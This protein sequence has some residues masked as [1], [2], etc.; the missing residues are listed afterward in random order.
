MKRTKQ[1]DL[2]RETIK[3]AKAAG[4]KS[5]EIP[6]EL[7]PGQL[8]EL[9]SLAKKAGAKSVEMRERQGGYGEL[10]IIFE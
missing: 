8:Y 10:R 4:A 1:L 7:P 2:V 3:A 9:I 6:G 5:V